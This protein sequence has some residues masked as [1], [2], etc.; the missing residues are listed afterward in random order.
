[1]SDEARA[2]QQAVLEQAAVLLAQ[3]G[4]HAELISATGD[5]VTEIEATAE[6][7]HA[8]TVVVGRSGRRGLHTRVA[9]HLVRR[10]GTDVLVVR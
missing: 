2:E 5:P 9:D 1:V 4:V 10:G 3:S 8:D 6:R 7:L